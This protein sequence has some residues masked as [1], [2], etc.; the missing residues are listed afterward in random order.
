MPRAHSLTP[1]RRE[2]AALAKGAGVSLVGRGAGRALEVGSQVT[3]AHLLGPETFG[4][5]VIGWSIFRLT[6]AMA[7][8][9]LDHGVIRYGSRYWPVDQGGV[10]SVVSQSVGLAIV[11]GL[12]IGGGVFLAAPWLAEQ[13][14]RQPPLT[15]VLRGFALA[16]ACVAGLKVMA[17]ATTVSQRMQYAIYTTEIVQ[18][19]LN[20]LLIVLFSVAG[21]GL[22][23]AVG[24]GV[25]S[26]A[27][28][29]LLA[30]YFL[31]RLFP[32]VFSRQTPSRFLVGEIL[33]FSLP[34]QLAGMCLLGLLWLDRLL[35]GYFLTP[36]DAGVYHAA[37]Q[38]AML[39]AVVLDAFSAV[40]TPMIAQCFHQGQMQRLNELFKVSTKWGLY[41]C[42]PFF[43]VVLVAPREIM[44]VIFGGSYEHGATVLTIL[45]IAQLINV[46]TGAT[47]RML[48]MTG[49]QQRWLSLTVMTLLVNIVLSWFL[50]P[51]L[52]V[53]GAAL[54]AAVAIGLLFVASLYEVKRTLGVWPYDGRYG[55]GMVATG[56]IVAVVIGVAWVPIVPAS[57]H[58]VCLVGAAL[59]VFT[60][61]LVM[62]GF[63]AEERTVLSALFP[64]RET[65]D[66]VESI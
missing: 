2:A 58:L 18:P 30:L 23:G 60:L 64:K 29:F 20:L 8:L 61:T 7:T 6:G 39:F 27:V 12:M 16:L 22:L 63:D 65:R 41:C 43:V 14:F 52:G 4:L 24:A 44:S 66:R 31:Y 62:L 17:A 13:V 25:C 59:G 40:F 10:K 9:G 51:A 47:S 55:K 1:E 36:A 49:H 53:V 37:A 54:G 19:A 50:I 46:G 32:A 26:H 15:D 11:A 33:T 3:L 35:I 48:L 28:A 21:F 56:V 42:L 34:T 38:V 5:Y 45:G 57:L